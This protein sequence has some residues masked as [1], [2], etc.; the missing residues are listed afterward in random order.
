MKYMKYGI[1]FD[2]AHND[3]VTIEKINFKN[4]NVGHFIEMDASA[5]VS[6]TGCTF[7]NVKKNSD[8]VKEAINLDTP[9]RETQGFHNDWST[10]DKTPNQNVTIANCKFSNLGRAIGTHKYSA[11]GEEQ[12]YHKNIVLRNNRIE[13]M[14]WDSPVRVMNWSDSVLENNVIS[15]VKQKGKSDT[16]GILVSGGVNVSIKNNTLSGMGRAIQCIAW[17]NSGPGSVYPI[18]YNNLTDQNKEDLKT[19]IGKK[20]GLSEYFVRINPVYN[21]FTNAEIVAIRKG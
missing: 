17:K 16:R 21:V 20:L 5:N 8:Y 7:K 4:V 9:D 11:N 13:N 6:V 15:N 18:T 2:V 14:L 10:Y 1:A 12:I 19:N 3:G